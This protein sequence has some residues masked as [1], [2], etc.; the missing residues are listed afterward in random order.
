MTRTTM[1]M[2]LGLG[3]LLTGCGPTASNPED[4]AP[5]IKPSL[6]K[7]GPAMGGSNPD[8]GKMGGPPPG[9]AAKGGGSGGP[10]SDIKARMES[11]EYR[12]IGGSQGPGGKAAAAPSEKVEPKKDEPKKDEPK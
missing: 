11:D 4:S 12:N 1:V 7:K 6:T 9:G 5:E 8:T 10:P 3:L 2:T